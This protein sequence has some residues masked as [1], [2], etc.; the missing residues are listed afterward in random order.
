[1]Y[2]RLAEICE[3]ANRDRSNRVLLL[4]AGDK[5]FAAGTAISRFRAFDKEQ[6]AQ[7]YEARIDRVLGALEPIAARSTRVIAS[8]IGRRRGSSR[9]TVPGISPQLGSIAR[10]TAITDVNNLMRFLRAL[11]TELPECESRA[12]R[13]FC[14]SVF[15]DLLAFIADRFRATVFD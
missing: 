9:A 8:N 5:A 13:R 10:P 3:Q 15:S 4:N 7:D 11:T 1:M 2:D 12:K 6:D 14:A